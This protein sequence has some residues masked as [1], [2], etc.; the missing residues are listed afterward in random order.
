MTNA[1]TP[2]RPTDDAELRRLYVDTRLSPNQITA[3]TGISQTTI[4]RRLR[5]LGVDLRDQKEAQAFRYSGRGD[6]EGLAQ[7][8]HVPADAMAEILRHFH[9]ID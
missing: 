1:H 4:R 9:F 2:R 6:L 7:Y 3:L 5:D 8:F